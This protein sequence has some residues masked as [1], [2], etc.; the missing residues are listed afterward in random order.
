MRRSLLSSPIE[1]AIA[2]A[3]GVSCLLVMSVASIPTA[4]KCID[5]EREVL[6]KFK[7]TIHGKLSSWDSHNDCCDWKGVGCDNFTGHVV[8]IDLSAAALR[9]LDIS[10]NQLSGTLPDC[11]S[12]LPSLAFL[13]LANNHNLSGSL[14]TSI[15][16]LA[17]LEGLHLDHNNFTGTLPSSMENCSSLVV[18]H[19][20]HNKLLGPIPDWVGENLTPLTVLV[21]GSNHFN[22]SV[23]TSL[24][25]LRSL[26]LLDLSVNHISGTLPDC[27]ANLTGMTVHEPH[28]NATISY[29]GV[30]Q[31]DA[32]DIVWKGRVIQLQ[33]TLGLIKSIDLSSNMLSG[34]IPTEIT[35]LDGLVSLNL[36]RNNL[37]GP[38]PPRI[39]NL[40][41]LETLDLSHNHLSG[42]IPRSLSLIHRMSFLN[43]SNNNLS[44]K[45]PDGTQLHSFDASTYTGNLGLCGDPLPNSCR[46]EPTHPNIE[47][48]DK[49]F[50]HDFYA[51]MG[52]GYAVGFL[53]V[54]VNMLFIGSYRFAYF[55]LLDDFANWAYVV[56]AIHK[57][58]FVRILGG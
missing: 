10:F 33:T 42:S 18:L 30:S 40:S 2:I 3:A 41:N 46:R 44:G 51:S 34:E 26:Q 50:C 11:W 37:R 20:G 47:E 38:I 15:G 14:P 27:L 55:K 29:G 43:V 54:I 6:L 53:G 24:C 12:N 7:Q 57:A 35:S 1:I 17:S 56:A 45:I 16:L 58:K 8:K 13:N 9:I 5:G 39:D 49:F 28:P 23:P 19:L 22:A 48:A 31:G 36:S 32:I 21:L 52:V 25:R 4:S